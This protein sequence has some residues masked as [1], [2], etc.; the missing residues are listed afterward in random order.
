MLVL[1]GITMMTL[2]GVG[3]DWCLCEA[4]L[5]LALAGVIVLQLGWC[6]ASTGVTMLKLDLCVLQLDWCCF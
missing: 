4:R 1:T 6:L 3:F 5:V 2:D